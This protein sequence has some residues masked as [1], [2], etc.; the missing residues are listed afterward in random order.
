MFPC[1]LFLDNA[2]SVLKP[3]QFKMEAIEGFRYRCRVRILIL[4][5]LKYGH[6]LNL[7]FAH[8]SLS[9]FCVL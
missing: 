8:S 4:Y 6:S 3:Y 5:V 7:G 9:F 2:D 1:W